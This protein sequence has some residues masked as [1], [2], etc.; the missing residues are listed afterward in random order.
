MNRSDYDRALAA[1]PQLR[2]IERVV[3]TLCELVRPSDHLCNGC[4]WEGIVKPLASPWVGW[5]REYVPGEADDPVPGELMGRWTMADLRGDDDP[6][7]PPATTETEKWLRTSP[8]FD[9][10]TDVWL[11]RL[12][13]ADPANGHGI[14]RKGQ[15]GEHGA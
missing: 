12:R 2:A 6:L 7:R 11:D 10:V 1:E 13:A 8:A 9:A 5:E 15:G 14:G 3:D 4:V